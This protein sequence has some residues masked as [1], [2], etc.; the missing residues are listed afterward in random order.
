MNKHSSKAIFTF[1]KTKAIISIQN[2]KN[3]HS[4][5]L[6]FMRRRNN[7]P[8]ATETYRLTCLYPDTKAPTDSSYHADNRT[9]AKDRAFKVTLLFTL[10][11]SDI[12]NWLSVTRLKTKTSRSMQAK[13]ALTEHPISLNT[14][15]KYR[16]A[17]PTAR[18]F[19]MPNNFRLMLR[20]F[21]C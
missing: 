13:L 7:L 16:Q 12:G 15:L 2:S 3:N 11:C 10:I 14:V 20:K 21:I 18:I 8:Y 17:V 4:D 5:C 19:T 9:V 6:Y 1:L